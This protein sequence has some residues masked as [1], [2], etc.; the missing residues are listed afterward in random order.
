MAVNKAQKK[1]K[2]L[3][4]DQPK[5][6]G[7]LA[8][9]VEQIKENPA[10]YLGAFLFIVLCFLA[11]MIYRAHS[12][13]VLRE[14]STAY[15]KAMDE[16]EPAARYEALKAIVDAGSKAENMPEIIYMTAET[17]FRAQKYDE[18]KALFER[19]RTE[20]PDAPFVP[21]AVEGLGFIAEDQGDYDAAYGYYQEITQ[22][23]PASF[24][25][26]RQPLNRGRVDE[27]RGKLAEAIEAYREQ[28]ALFPDSQVAAQAEAA[29]DRLG[30]EHPELFAAEAAAPPEASAAPAESVAAPA[31][32]STAAPELAP[33]VGGTLEL[34]ATDSTAPQTPVETP[35]PEGTLEVPAPTETSEQPVA[36]E[37]AAEPAP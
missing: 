35:A 2:S 4:E 32:P 18:A 3:F 33:E 10:L 30:Q 37:A 17:A 6:K 13:S 26:R 21:D 31:A 9:L 16:Q 23:W 22:K 20:S 5:Q 28:G 25:A 36:S 29:L 34:P 24:T 8:A 12:K 15:A 27:Q 11:G 14:T 19:V 1:G 7:D